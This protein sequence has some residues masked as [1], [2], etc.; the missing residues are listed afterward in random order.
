MGGIA[1][2]SRNAR[3]IEFGLDKTASVITGAAAIMIAV[4]VSFAAAPIAT[5]SQLG[6]G[7]TV[8]ILLD[9]TVVRIVLLPGPDV[10]AR[11]PRL[12]CA[13]DARQAAAAPRFPPGSRR[14][15][16]AVR[17]S[18]AGIQGCD[19]ARAASFPVR[20]MVAA[21]L[22]AVLALSAVAAAAAAPDQ[23]EYVSR[24]ESICR[25]NVEQTQR[26]VQGVR[27]DIQAGTLR[28]RGAKALQRRAD[29]RSD[30][31]GDLRR[32]APPC[33]CGAARQVVS[34]PEAP[35]VLSAAERRRRC[36][37]SSIV[38][39]QHNAVRF[40]HTGNLANDV[41]IAYGFNYCRFK[42]SRFG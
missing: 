27:S 34:L 30:G 35:G 14:R 17:Q 40:V 8:A 7:L 32:A 23:A 42:F 1:S 41:V 16:R 20:R 3:A 5:V 4:F 38:P 2:A 19:L 9:A 31:G 24:L 11:R 28:D 21:A 29:L 15:S 10:A 36:R 12:A 26:A 18:W 39:Y 25:P 33:R 37:P 6:V 22:L 13:R